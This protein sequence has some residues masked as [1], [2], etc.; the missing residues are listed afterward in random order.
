MENGIFCRGLGCVRRCECGVRVVCVCVAVC[1]GGYLWCVCAVCV[2]LCVVY[3]LLCVQ[4]CMQC[5][6]CCVCMQ[7]CVLLCVFRCS[8]SASS[9][10]TCL[11]STLSRWSSW[12]RRVRTHARA[13]LSIYPAHT[14]YTLH[15]RTRIYVSIPR[16]HARRSMSLSCLC[17]HEPW[18]CLNVWTYEYL[19]VY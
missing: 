15:M 2:F 3:V 4:V 5:A 14:R 18:A 1:A 12:R 7:M 17:T 16:T 8:C 13:S 10:K 11:I 19:C 6:C 9:C